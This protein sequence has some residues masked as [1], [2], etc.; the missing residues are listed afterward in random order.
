METS[1]ETILKINGM[2][3]GKCAGKVEAALKEVEGVTRVTVDLSAREARVERDGGAT[4]ELTEAV[5]EA[6]YQ[7]AGVSKA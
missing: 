4:T 3:C 6:G 7:V 2:N 1:M 5:T